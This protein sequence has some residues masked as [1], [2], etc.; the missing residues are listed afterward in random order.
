[1][2]VGSVKISDRGGGFISYS[3]SHMSEYVA[4]VIEFPLEQRIIRPQIGGAYM[5]DAVNEFGAQLGSRVYETRV[6]QRRSQ[7]EVAEQAGVG[8]ATVG[9][10]ERGEHVP[11][12]STLNRVARSLD[13]PLAFLLESGPPKALAAGRERRLADEL[14]YTV[15]TETDHKQPRAIYELLNT[16][17]R[18]AVWR[19]EDNS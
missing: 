11:D 1:V 7:A 2:V 3:L 9:R 13:V 8:I 6:L 12:L 16:V 18:N 15:E 5:A 10:I 17:A 19:H 4:N 14:A